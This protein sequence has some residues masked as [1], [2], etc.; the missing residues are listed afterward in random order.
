VRAGQRLRQ[1]VV[2]D[3]L[4]FRKV[5]SIRKYGSVGVCRGLCVLDALESN[6]M[7]A[8]AILRGRLD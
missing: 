1:L 3:S 8:R 7:R 2:A 4:C 6:R 5:L